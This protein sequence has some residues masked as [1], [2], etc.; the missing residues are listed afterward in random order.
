M[1][2]NI[3]IVY[4]WVD[5]ADPNFQSQFE[6]SLKAVSSSPSQAAVSSQRF[7]D[8][9]ERKY[10]LRSLEAFA[11]WFRKVHIVT[12]Q[13]T[14]RWLD[15][16]NEKVSV[17]AHDVIFSNKSDLPTFNSNAIES[18]LHRIPTLSKNF[19]YFNDDVFLGRAASLDD[20][21]TAKGQYVFLQ[22]IPLHSN[23]DEGPIHDRAYAYTQSLI[24]ELWGVRRPR[25]LP[26][27]AP[28]LY[29]RDIL[30]CLENLL[31][32]EYRE[33]SRHRFRSE[34]DLVLRVLYSYY[35]LECPEQ[36]NRHKAK[37]LGFPNYRLVLMDD[38]S[39]RMLRAF[40]K[41]RLLKPKFFCIN[42]ELG[43]TS[44]EHKTVVYLR[45]FLRS[46]FP[47]PSS[48]ELRTQNIGSL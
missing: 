32:K 13:P 6:T 41:I 37:R 29:D 33:T 14:P 2:S 46:Y 9:E 44:R 17:V 26:A 43:D 7:R 16:T 28:Q 27:H 22:H 31:P 5:G 18:H 34:N 4:T 21:M 12:N 8:N 47:R 39:R 19:L 40:W 23:L 42:D 25:L 45:R 48:F 24:D 30:A 36:R 38:N 1:E 35:L 20:F 11:P 3:D 10:S 15:L